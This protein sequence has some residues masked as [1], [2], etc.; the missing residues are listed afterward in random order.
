MVRTST[1]LAFSAAA[2]TSAARVQSTEFTYLGDLLPTYTQAKG[3]APYQV[4]KRWYE[5]G[6][7]QWVLQGGKK[8]VRHFAK[9]VF[10]HAPADVHYHLEGKYSQFSACVGLDAYAGANV[11][12]CGNHDGVVFKVAVDGKPVWSIRKR[13]GEVRTCFNI[14]LEVVDPSKNAQVL[15]LE[16]D[17]LQNSDCDEAEW[18]DAKLYEDPVVDCQQLGSLVPSFTSVGWGSYW[19]NRNWHANGFEIAG[20]KYSSGVFAHAPSR[21]IYPLHQKFDTFSTCVGLDD[22]IKEDNYSSKDCGKVAFK[23]LVD[24]KQQA[25]GQH[26]SEIVMKGMQPVECFAVKVTG[27]KH[28]EL[29]VDQME[30]SKCDESE[31]VNANVCREAPKA[32]D[33]QVSDFA[34]WTTC[35]KT[36]GTGY[37]T[38]TRAQTRAAAWGGHGC[39]TLQETRACETVSCPI[40]CIESKWSEWVRCSRTCGGGVSFRYRSEDRSSAFG[41]KSCASLQEKKVCGTDKCPIDCQV[42]DWSNW[43]ACTAKCGG[44]YQWQR[45]QVLTKNSNNGKGCPVLSQKRLCNDSPC[46]IDCQM[47]E[48]SAWSAC[49]VDCGGGTQ[50]RTRTMTRENQHNGKTCPPGREDRACNISECPIN[51]ELS[52]WGNWPQCSST[53][54]GGRQTRYRSIEVTS[55]FGGKACGALTQP[56]ACATKSCPVDCL[57]GSWGPWQKCDKTCGGGAEQRFRNV[58]TDALNGGKQCGA[59]SQNRPCNVHACPTDCNDKGFGAWGKC[60]K[61]C[62]NGVTIRHRTVIQATFGGKPCPKLQMRQEQSCNTFACATDCKVTSWSPWSTCDKV[63]GGGSM[64][65]TRAHINDPAF[66]GKKCPELRQER[67]CNAQVCPTDCQLSPFS[68]WSVCNRKCGG[69]KQS[70]SAAVLTAAANGGKCQA[71]KQTRACNSEACPLDCIVTSWGKPSACSHSCVGVN[72]DE[73]QVFH[74]REVSRAP[75]NGGKACPVL[76]EART[77]EAGRPACPVDCVL[78]EWSKFS[79]CTNDCGGG[80][81]TGTRK[82][83]TAAANKGKKC[84]AVKRTRPCNSRPCPIKCIVTDFAAW[85]SCSRTCGKGISTRKRDIVVRAGARGAYTNTCPD[86]VQVRECEV[87]KCPVDCELDLWGDWSP[88][89]KSCGTGFHFRE[90]DITTMPKLGGKGCASVKDVRFCNETPCANYVKHPWVAYTRTAEKVVN[91]KT[92]PIDQH[93][94]RLAPTPKPTQRFIAPTPAPTV[95]VA[96]KSCKWGPKRTV[97]HGWAGAGYGNQFCNL[98]RCDN[99]SLKGENARNCLAPFRHR[100]TVCKSI[101]CKFQYSYEAK[102]ELMKV[103]HSNANGDEQTGNHHCAYNLGN[104]ECEC[105]CYQSKD[106]AGRPVIL[107]WQSSE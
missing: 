83:L 38:R 96:K 100:G 52:Q 93:F 104:N 1:V 2:L 71:N 33:C 87:R 40:D 61:S 64:W 65:R 60:S 32:I 69:G 66:G 17:K 47:T 82:V 6:F 90:R 34:A 10:T 70:R 80:I 26:G 58:D 27:A 9:G 101:S 92:A 41:G 42:T 46:K 103:T 28:L 91:A 94:G 95:Y 53:C 73:G 18:T 15:A 85:S 79:K 45:R 39:P 13:M 37:Q 19:V 4:N 5:N 81:R 24:G 57:M 86:T 54:G 8:V 89:S 55:A 31:W 23:V 48:W 107:N 11:K 49:S 7:N 105:H 43:D 62:G 99:G 22:G 44:G 97:V 68:P 3:Y 76:V 25:L 29:I 88:C 14:A 12:S 30:D 21:I 106:V 50:K 20:A 84:Q 72:G 77:C 59:R 35:S 63:C 75:L 102:R 78:S 16:V 74:R 56:R 51:C 67:K 36:C 98:V